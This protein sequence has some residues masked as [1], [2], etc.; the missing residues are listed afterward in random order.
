MEA[1][2][3]VIWRRFVVCVHHLGNLV[4]AQLLNR[5]GVVLFVRVINFSFLIW[6]HES[7]LEFRPVT[8][9]LLVFG[10]GH[11]LL[12]L[13]EELAAL[14]RAQSDSLV[15]GKSTGVAVLPA[16]HHEPGIVILGFECSSTVF[17]LGV[18][19]RAATALLLLN[20]RLR[21]RFLLLRLIG[22]VGLALFV[23]LAFGLAGLDLFPALLLAF[24]GPP[25]TAGYAQF[26]HL[27]R[28]FLAAEVL[29]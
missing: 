17:G 29:V 8:G 7:S 12:L 5:L 24:G 11:V 9:L 2:L 18:L 19:R 1:F 20:Y 6:V 13:L 3:E 14:P 27:R 16:I 21:L 10:L 26:V 28:I 25:V 23:L 22:L 4:I 15:S